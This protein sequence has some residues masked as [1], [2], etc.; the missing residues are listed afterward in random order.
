MLVATMQGAVG[1]SNHNLMKSNM[2]QYFTDNNLT[3]AVFPPFLQYYA[4]A[5]VPYYFQDDI[6]RLRLQKHFSFVALLYLTTTLR[7]RQVLQS[8]HYDEH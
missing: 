8:H 7:H 3:V 6:P 5:G 1:S 4:G 2:S